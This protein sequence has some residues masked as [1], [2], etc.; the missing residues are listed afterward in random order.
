MAGALIICTSQ[1]FTQLIFILLESLQVY[2]N[3][4]CTKS[5]LPAPIP[6]RLFNF[7]THT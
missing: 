2:E 5:I 1:Y 3:K 6:Y 7:Q 4:N